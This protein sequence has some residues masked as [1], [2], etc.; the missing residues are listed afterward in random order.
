MAKSPLIGHRV[1][2]LC[3][4]KARVGLMTSG[5]V[6]LTC[7]GCNI[8]LMTRSGK[9]DQLVRDLPKI[10]DDAPANTPAPV[11]KIRTT[12]VVLPAIPGPVPPPPAID[13][14]PVRTEKASPFAYWK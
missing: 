7:D 11:E 12:T 9:S 1:C 2:P 6:I 3:G 14:A 10:D 8:Q 4:G 5:C 13:P